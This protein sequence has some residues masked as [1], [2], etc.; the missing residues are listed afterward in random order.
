MIGMGAV[1]AL[2]CS[3]AFV[4]L[5]TQSHARS[6]S[7]DVTENGLDTAYNLALVGDSI[8]RGSAEDLRIPG[9]HFSGCWIDRCFASRLQLKLDRAFEAGEMPNINVINVGVG[10]ATSRDYDPNDYTENDFHF[11]GNTLITGTTGRPLFHN[12]PTSR[13]AVIYLG[14]NDATGFFEPAGIVQVEEY[15]AHLRDMRRSLIR[16]GVRYVVLVTPPIP[17][18]WRNTAKGD[19]MRG[20]RQAI[21]RIC[22]RPRGQFESCLLDLQDHYPSDEWLGNAV[23]PT[24]AGHAYISTR[25]FEHVSKILRRFKPDRRHH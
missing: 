20:Y 23:H 16:N 25:L 19:L 13:M 3:L 14:T 15:E 6:P 4:A 22:E 8:T 1:K 11:F 5:T 2:A 10:G 7:E 12:I 9:F 17:L 24:L 21:L 18:R